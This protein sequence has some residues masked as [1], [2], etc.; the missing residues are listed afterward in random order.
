MAKAKDIRSRNWVF[1]VYPDSAPKNWREILDG[2]HVQ[3]IESPLHDKDTNPDGTIK[4]AHWH[5]VLLF[6]SKKSFQQ[7]KEITDELHAPIPQKVVNLK[8]QVRYLIHLDNPEKYKYSR[9]KI[10]GHCG[11]DVDGY[12]QLSYS[13]KNELLWDMIKYIRENNVT[14]FAQFL[15]Y[16][17]DSEQCDWF[18]VA[19]NR[20]T[21]ALKTVIDSNY[22]DSRPYEEAVIQAADG[23]QEQARELAKQGFS[24]REIARK[25]EISKTAVYKYLKSD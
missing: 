9:D 16:I 13:L 3:W 18:D 25:L 22:Q 11:A 20:N 4:K 19:M 21:L 23:R 17:Q 14:S 15:G 2:Y 24:Q 12:F 6:G 5:V 10:I 1:I 8:G 7:V